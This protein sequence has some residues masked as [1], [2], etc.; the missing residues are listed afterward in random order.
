MLACGLKVKNANLWSQCWIACAH[1]RGRVPASWS[2]SKMKP[3]TRHQFQLIPLSLIISWG[4]QLLCQ[5]YAQPTINRGAT[6]EGK[7]QLE[8]ECRAARGVWKGQESASIIRCPGI[9]RCFRL[10]YRKSPCPFYR[11]WV[12][13]S[14][15]TCLTL[16]TTERNYGHLDK[17]TLAVVFQRKKFHRFPFGRHF[18]IYT[19]HKPLLG[20]LSSERVTP[21]MASSRIQRLALTLL[22]YE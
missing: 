14:N 16:A 19:D 21:L 8:I 12:R 15:S 13:E 2:W 6:T 11:R 4:W 1:W 22:T 17:K 5:V 10:L 7:Y 9:L 3:S 20:L 18:K